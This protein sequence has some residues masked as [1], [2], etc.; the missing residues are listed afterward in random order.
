MII[1]VRV[2]SLDDSW[3]WNGLVLAEPVSAALR[4]PPNTNK[5]WM[6]RTW[7]ITDILEGTV[8]AKKPEDVAQMIFDGLENGENT[9]LR[10]IGHHISK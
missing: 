2:A 7:Q 5:C 4:N 8:R 3:E 6:V 10:L 1:V 9:P